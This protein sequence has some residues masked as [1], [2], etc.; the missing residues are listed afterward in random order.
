MVSGKINTS[1]DKIPNFLKNSNIYEYLIGDNDDPE[2]IIDIIYYKQDLTILNVEDF[3]HLLHT[4]RFWN[5]KELPVEVYDYIKKNKDIIYK[6]LKTLKVD[7]YDF[8]LFKE[9]EICAYTYKYNI[10]SEC[11]INGYLNLLKYFHINEKFD[12][13]N[14]VNYYVQSNIITYN[15]LPCLE[16]IHKNG[17]CIIDTASINVCIS[18][19]R[20]ECLDYILN[21][22]LCLNAYMFNISSEYGS[23]KCLKYLYE[24]KCPTDNNV[25]KFGI[26][27]KNIECVKYL[28][29]NNFPWNNRTFYWTA[30]ACNL[31]YIKYLYENDCFGDM[32]NLFVSIIKKNSFEC[33]KYLYE[34]NFIIDN[35]D[36]ETI[37]RYDKIIIFKYIY[38]KIIITDNDI[39]L[40]SIYANIIRYDRINFLVYIC[41]NNKISFNRHFYERANYF[42]SIKCFNFLQ[43][44]EKKY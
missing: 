24:K 14:S 34:N 13:S 25:L 42:N 17:A 31:K 8:E 29:N 32:S 11:C 10:L 5:I 15:H 43:N 4:F 21:T 39:N 41:E 28:R 18:H 26:S 30:V 7:F 44:R 37:I 27:D 9:C 2:F 20:V 1:I 36:M 6:K 35:Y 33:F 38:E 19:D 23:L 22:G 40:D 3:V 12:F 16:Y